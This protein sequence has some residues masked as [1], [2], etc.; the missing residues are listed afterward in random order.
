MEKRIFVNNV[1]ARSE[2]TKQSNKEAAVIPHPFDYAQGRAL[3]RN[4]EFGGAGVTLHKWIP[5]FRLAA[6]P[7]SRVLRLP[8]LRSCLRPPPRLASEDAGAGQEDA[9]ARN[10][11]KSSLCHCEEHSDE[12]ISFLAKIPY[13]GMTKRY[14]RNCFASL[15]MKKYFWYCCLIF[16]LSLLFAPQQ[17]KAAN[18]GRFDMTLV[19]DSIFTPGKITVSMQLADSVFI[20]SPYQFRVSIFSAGTLI[21]QQTLAASQKEP[22]VFSLEFPE[23]KA[24]TDGRCRCELF[25]GEQFVSSQEKSIVLWPSV[26]VFPDKTINNR[27]IW[28]YDT[29]GRLN[30]IFR[31]MEIKFSDAT[32]QAVREFGRPEI[33]VIGQQ[34]DPN[35]VAVITDRLSSLEPKPVVIWLHQ[36][37]LPYSSKIEI[38]AKDNIPANIKYENKSPLLNGLNIDDILTMAVNSSYVKIKNEDITIESA[39]SETTK[40]EKYSLC[41]LCA[42]EEKNGLY[43]IYCQLPV[44]DGDPRGIILL[45]NILKFAQKEAESRIQK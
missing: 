4:P 31:K 9:E 40:D 28:T 39:V 8:R 23:V 22:I 45:N 21:R 26:A 1:I 38:P 11:G 32:F 37:Q 6:E 43:T 3:M 44:T 14:T 5:T 33:V 20:D 35:S 24:R 12:A 29:S 2:T 34:L 42:T 15:P 41:Y 13:A 10:D 25:I 36:K 30:E 17:S 19:Q 18:L 27:T 16:F 7:F